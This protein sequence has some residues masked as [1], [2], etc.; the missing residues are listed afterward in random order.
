MEGTFFKDMFVYGTIKYKNKDEYLGQAHE[1]LP[2][3][4][5]KMTQSDGYY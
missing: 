3:G 5:G 2:H 1:E 4:E